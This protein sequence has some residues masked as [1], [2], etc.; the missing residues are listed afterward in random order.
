MRTTFVVPF[1]SLLKQSGLGTDDLRG[2]VQIEADKLLALIKHL[3]RGIHVDE[4][5]YRQT[6]DDVD[7]A[8]KSGSYDSSKHHFVDE[9]Y[10][11]GR[12]L[13]LVRALTK[14]GMSRPIPMLQKALNSA[15]SNRR[16]NI[17]IRTA[18]RRD[19]FRRRIKSHA[20]RCITFAPKHGARCVRSTRVDV[21]LR[22]PGS[23]LSCFTQAGARATSGRRKAGKSDVSRWTG[24][25]DR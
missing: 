1:L 10:F 4:K 18:T 24:R 7:L 2:V 23:T 20:G 25:Q 8:I 14:P 9:G 22:I 15:T 5:W 13:G 3:L 16:R 17:S 11:E 21:G 6:Y 19:A 12:R